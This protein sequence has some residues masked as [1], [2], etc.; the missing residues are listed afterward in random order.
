MEPQQP[1]KGPNEM[2]CSSCGAVVKKRAEICPECGVATDG[3]AVGVSPTTESSSSGIATGGS[4]SN[5]TKY[6]VGGVISGLVGFVFL[7]IIFGP[8]SLYC[9]YT[10]YQNHDE[11]KGIALMAWGGASLVVGMAVGALILA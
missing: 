6:L 7:P 8:I 11:T 3:A 9:G 10:V 2:Y 1:K 5:E 4:S